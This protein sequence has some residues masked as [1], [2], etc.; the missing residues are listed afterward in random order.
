MQH[1]IPL[2]LCDSMSGSPGSQVPTFLVKVRKPT[3]LLPGG[4]GV[5]WRACGADELEWRPG[6]EKLIGFFLR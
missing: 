6:K 4:Y 1:S 5:P 2:P 3:C